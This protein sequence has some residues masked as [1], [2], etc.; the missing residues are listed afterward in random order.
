LNKFLSMAFVG[1]LMIMVGNRAYGQYFWIQ[2][3]PQRP[4]NV[5]F[6]LFDQNQLVGTLQAY[7][8]DLNRTPIIN[9]DQQVAILIAPD[10]SYRTH[11]LA[12]Y[13]VYRAGNN[14]QLKWGWERLPDDDPC[15]GQPGA[16]T[17]GSRR[18][19]V[20]ETMVVEIPRSFLPNLQCVEQTPN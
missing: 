4:N 1:Y 20:L 3:T 8:W 9:W 12:L 18:G 10:K 13:G 11:A 19:G 17:Q 6:V 2:P 16:C 15:G 14:Q 5:C 7:G